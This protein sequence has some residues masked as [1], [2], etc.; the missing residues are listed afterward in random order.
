Y[1]PQT[2]V[3]PTP[4]E[5]PDKAAALPTLPSSGGKASPTRRGGGG[6]GVGRRTTP[7]GPGA[8]APPLVPTGLPDDRDAIRPG[9]RVLLVVEND[10]NFARILLN[11]ARERGFKGLVALRAA[12]GLELARRLNPDAI[13]LDLRLPDIDGWKVLEQLK[14]DSATRHIPVHII[15]VAEDGPRSRR[16]G[17]FAHLKKPVS[18]EDLSEAFGKIQRFLERRVRKLLVV[19]ADES[20]RNS[21]VELI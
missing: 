10:V 21:M 5:P 18:R 2:Y 1:L 20:Q 11:T 6:N 15:S 19:E 8:E 13:T 16:L 12:D 4:S 7:N 3:A 14:R 17:A 9:D